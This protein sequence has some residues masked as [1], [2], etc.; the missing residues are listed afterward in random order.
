MLYSLFELSQNFALQDKARECV[1]K[2]L[3]KHKGQ[4]TYEALSEMD[5]I[6]NCINGEWIHVKADLGC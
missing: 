1:R 4:F 5:Y 6:E 3:A 2:V